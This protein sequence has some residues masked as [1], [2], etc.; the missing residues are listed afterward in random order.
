[1]YPS[2]GSATDSVSFANHVTQMSQYIHSCYQ[3]VISQ[4]MDFRFRAIICLN[5]L[6][7]ELSQS[8][9]VVTHL[10]GDLNVQIQKKDDV[11]DDLQCQLKLMQTEI[12]TLK[13]KEHE[14]TNVI[15]QLKAELHSA[16]SH[17]QV[18]DS[19]LESLV[20]KKENLEMDVA[21]LKQA[22]HLSE[23]SF[24]DAPRS[25][26]NV[27]SGFHGANHFLLKNGVCFAL[28]VFDVQ[29]K[30]WILPSHF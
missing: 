23:S 15:K 18:Q 14:N 7:L 1:M 19:E 5:A 6:S 17:I 25:G 30:S 9:N 16:S 20:K 26:I 22:I 21:R 13:D 28:P 11:I 3:N 29:S 24:P 27:Q 10:F 2:V 8:R 4:L 12:A